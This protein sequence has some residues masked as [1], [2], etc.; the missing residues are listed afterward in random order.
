MAKNNLET[1]LRLGKKTRQERG[2]PVFAVVRSKR[3]VR[4]NPKRRNWRRDKMN[5]RNWRK[6]K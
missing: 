2:V 5:T 4:T 6:R 3:K 1:K